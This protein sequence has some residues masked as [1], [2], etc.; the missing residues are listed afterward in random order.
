MSHSESDEVLVSRVITDLVAGALAEFRRARL[1]RTQG[2]AREVGFVCGERVAID[3]AK[4]AFAL[5]YQEVAVVGFR[6]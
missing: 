4:V 2:I 6:L 1:L 3:K 5:V